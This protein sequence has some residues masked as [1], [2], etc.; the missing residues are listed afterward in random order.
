MDGLKIIEVDF[1]IRLPDGSLLALEIKRG[2]S[3]YYQHQ[4]DL[5]KLLSKKCGTFMDE[6]RAIEQLCLPN[7]SSPPF[8]TY[9][10]R[11]R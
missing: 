7:G 1:L 8:P 5:D 10:V 4:K 11:I 2:G 9:E 3:P 6:T